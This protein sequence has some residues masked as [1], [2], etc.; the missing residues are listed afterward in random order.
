[1]FILYFCVCF[2]FVRL[3]HVCEFVSCLRF[4]HV[5]VFVSCLCVCFI[6]VCFVSYFRLTS[7][8]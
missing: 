7:I 5:C 3:F 1:M 6:F 4:F 8:F 2:M